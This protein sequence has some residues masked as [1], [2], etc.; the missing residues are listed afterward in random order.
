MGSVN[1]T[2]ANGNLASAA[3]TD[4]GVTGIVMT[5]VTES[6]GYT[7]GTPI[8][9]TSMVDVATAGITLA[10]NPFAIKNLQ[11]FYNQAPAGT[12][13]WVMLVAASMTVASMADKTN[14]S[15]AIKLLNAA[16][17]A[18]K[19]IAVLAD[20]KAVH[21]GGGT[22]TIT[23]G[24]NADVY[25]AATNL[26]ALINTFVAAENPLRGLV[27][28]SSYSGTASALSTLNSGTT[29][30]RVGFV[31]GDTQ[32][33]DATYPSAAVG[34][35]L[36]TFAAVPVQQKISW[37]GAG[38]LSNTNGYLASV[39]LTLTNGDMATIAGKGYI[40][41]MLYSNVSGFRWSGDPTATATTDDYYSM[42][43]GRVIDKAQ[44]LVYNYLVQNVDATVP[45]NADGTIDAGY[46]AN[47]QAKISGAQGVLTVNMTNQGNC[48][49]STAFV[50]PTQ[51]IVSTN[52]LAVVISVN[53]VGYS[54]TIN[55]TL[56]L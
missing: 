2:I 14:A 30:N 11:E 37:V 20:D 53:S 32:I 52:T 34:L 41:F 18:I 17:G 12:K 3:Q 16:Q 39:A 27:G 36:G 48:D 7:L 1:I 35:C 46:A 6:G 38:P 43:R 4:D 51:N 19:I 21:T 13:L 25:T 50:D 31:I 23:N 24:M 22:I 55:V 15:G 9:V 26:K 8:L 5:G 42:A 10:N 56:G 33:W 49:G 29:N 44:R 45:S 40:T 54:T 47:L 28:C